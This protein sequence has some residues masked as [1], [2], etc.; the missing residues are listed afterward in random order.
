MN[1]KHVFISYKHEEHSRLL[2]ETLVGKLKDHGYA[3]WYDKHIDGGSR[4]RI[5]I[6]RAL[7]AAFAVIVIVTP[8]SSNSTYVIYEWAY[9]LATRKA[10]IPILL[11]GDRTT[12]HP[13]IDELH[14]RD[15][16]KQFKEEWE[17]VLQDIENEAR[18]AGI[19][20]A[21]GWSERA[22]T[23]PSR[24]DEIPVVRVLSED[25]HELLTE[26]FRLVP[27]RLISKLQVM[28]LLESRDLDGTRSFT[29]LL[30][31]IIALH[32][33]TDGQ[34]FDK[35]ADRRLAD[36]LGATCRKILFLE[37]KHNESSS[38]DDDE[39]IDYDEAETGRVAITELQAAYRKLRTYISRSYPGFH[40][41]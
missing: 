13:R 11:E 7:D 39:F 35:M 25:D 5:E 36:L 15:F 30:S 16:R 12:I 4:W 1:P 27:D 20:S 34:P 40:L 23:Q 3:V 17:E 21:V 24:T 6:D 9:A 31:W 41:P 22:P 33:Y 28:D 32:D 37:S 38:S 26:F 2:L 14:F 19:Q 8:A 10:V 29:T 18:I